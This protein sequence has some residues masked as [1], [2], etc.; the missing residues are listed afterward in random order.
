M[1]LNQNYEIMPHKLFE[2][3]T[4][5]TLEKKIIENSRENIFV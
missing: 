4:N 5:D 3:V 1:L 2:I